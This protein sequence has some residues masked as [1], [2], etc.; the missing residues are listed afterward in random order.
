MLQR[1]RT[2]YGRERPPDNALRQ[3]DRSSEGTAFPPHPPSEL[4]YPNPLLPVSTATLRV[5]TAPP[6]RPDSPVRMGIPQT[7]G[8]WH[9]ARVG[10]T[11]SADRSGV[12]FSSI[13]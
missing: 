4:R 9:A 1:M 5:G 12:S 13:S 6:E 3:S 11:E 2:P 10:I 7:D 8:I